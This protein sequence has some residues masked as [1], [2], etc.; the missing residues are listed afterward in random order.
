MQQRDEADATDDVIAHGNPDADED[1]QHGNAP[2]ISEDATALDDSPD[3][4]KEAEAH[5]NASAV[6]KQEH[7]N[8]SNDGQ[9]GIEDTNLPAIAEDNAQKEDIA[10]Q[11]H[12][13]TSSI[14]AIEHRGWLLKAPE[15][16]GKARRRFFV[17]KGADFRYFVEEGSNNTGVGEKGQ[18]SLSAQTQVQ[19]HG[20]EIMI[21][22]EKRRWQL[23]GDDAGDAR[24]WTNALQGTTDYVFVSLQSSV[25]IICLLLSDRRCYGALVQLC[26]L[27]CNTA[28]RRRCD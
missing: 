20:S 5:D 7:S 25:S 11:D 21:T 18:I 22:T 13:D 17:L 6:E 9:D 3:A 14:A 4:I 27:G 23:R 24:Q 12:E 10:A 15:K 1:V 26:E 19:L 16:R 2:G 8:S 28:C